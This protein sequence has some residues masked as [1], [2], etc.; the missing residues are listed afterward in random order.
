MEFNKIFIKTQ[1]HG[2][3]HTFKN[4]FT[5]IFSVFNNKQYPNRLELSYPILYD[6]AI[7]PLKNIFSTI[8]SVRTHF[9]AQAQGVC[10]F[11]PMNPIQ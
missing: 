6:L 5:T 9:A 8:I 7:L 3:I 11:S 4:Y 1:S 10:N 2:I